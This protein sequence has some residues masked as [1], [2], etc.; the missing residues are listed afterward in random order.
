[1]KK[2]AILFITLICMANLTACVNA[3]TETS[4]TLEGSRTTVEIE[5]DKNYDNLKAQNLFHSFSTQKTDSIYQMS[6]TVYLSS[7]RNLVDVETNDNTEISIWGTLERK[8][9]EIKF[10]F[11]DTDGNIT[12]LIDSENNQDNIMKVE[13]SLLLNVGSGKFYFLGNS[14]IFDF[15]LNFS[16][17]EEVDYSMNNM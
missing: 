8:E 16:A 14:C 3:N 15:N 2:I 7:E 6:G 13:L 12:T 10:L 9:G 11:E 5:L 1:M 17:P 4:N